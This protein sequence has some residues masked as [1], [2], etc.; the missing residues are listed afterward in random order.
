MSKK[1]TDAKREAIKRYDAANTK[2]IHLKLNRNTDAEL[3]AWLE[4]KGNVQGYIKDLINFDMKYN[5]Q[6]CVVVTER[7]KSCKD[8]NSCGKRYDCEYV[9]RLGETTRINCPLWDQK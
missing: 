8:C 5:V 9:P 1:L 6:S 4:S 2:Q 3:I 7:V